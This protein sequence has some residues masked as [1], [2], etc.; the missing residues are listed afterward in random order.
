[1]N[2][3]RSPIGGPSAA[4]TL[5]D[6]PAAGPTQQLT[7]AGT[8]TELA[9]KTPTGKATDAGAPAPAL[10]RHVFVEGGDQSPRDNRA[11]DYSWRPPANAASQPH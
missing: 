4:P 7:G 5:P 11:D 9:R 10:V 3:F 6:R 2:I 8:A 1:P